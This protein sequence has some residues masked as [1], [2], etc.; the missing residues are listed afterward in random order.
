[1]VSGSLW[2]R[3]RAWR[4]VMAIPAF[5]VLDTQPGL[6]NIE[7]CLLYDTAPSYG[8]LDTDC[9]RDIKL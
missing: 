1:M 6:L 3:H 2:A 5:D 7:F 4:Q 8:L 9:S